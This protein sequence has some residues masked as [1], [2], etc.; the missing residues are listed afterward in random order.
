MLVGSAAVLAVTVLVHSIG[1]EVLLFRRQDRWRELPR[2]FGT[3]ALAKQILRATWHIASLFG[4]VFVAVLF[5]ASRL[6]A[7][8][9]ADRFA[10][11]AIAASSIASA[12]L[13]LVLTRAR[14]PGWVALAV[15]GVLCALALRG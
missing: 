1:G 14:H 7:L 3:D 9:E 11:T 12:V 13:V 6:A 4:V 10:V 8:S 15:A 5:R 2:A